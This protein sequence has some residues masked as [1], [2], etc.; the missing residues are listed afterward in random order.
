[1]AK[2]RFSRI[3]PLRLAHARRIVAS[4]PGLGRSQVAHLARVSITVVRLVQE[5]AT[6]E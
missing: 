2:G 1:M 4:Q 6:G 5:E 3:D